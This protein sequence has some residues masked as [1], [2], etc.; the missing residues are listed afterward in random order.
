VKRRGTQLRKD[1]NE[2]T[3]SSSTE[4]ARLVCKGKNSVQGSRQKKI[5]FRFGVRGSAEGG[6]KFGASREET[7]NWGGEKKSA[8]GSE[9]PKKRG[10]GLGVAT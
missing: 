2:G 9:L 4:G 5:S 3:I 10:R 6:E 8:E 1:L 7:L